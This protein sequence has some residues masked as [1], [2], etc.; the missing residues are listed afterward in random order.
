M[1]DSSAIR[2]ELPTF[3]IQ[4]KR[5]RVRWEWLV[6]ARG[7][8]PMMRGSEASRAAAAY[9]ANRA[10][11]LLIATSTANRKPAPSRVRK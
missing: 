7:G 10:V 5:K 3:E 8:D 6:S 11:F 4:L 2:A 1:Y 9:K